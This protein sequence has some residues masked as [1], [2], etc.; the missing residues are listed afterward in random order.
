MLREESD[1]QASC[2]LR[3]GYTTGTCATA[4]SLAAA[5]LLLTRQPVTTMQVTLPRG[6]TTRLELTHCRLQDVY[7]E[8]GTLKDAGDD[9]DVTHQALVFAKVRL[10]DPA[11]I[12]FQAGQGVGTVTRPGLPVPLGE[13]AINPTPRRMM[14][15]HLKKLAQQQGYKG[16]FQVTIGVH[17]G[18]ELAKRTLNGRLGIVGGLSILGTT[19]IVR[20]FSCSAY[21]ASIHQTIDVAR[22]NG[23]CHLAACTGAASEQTIRAHY[24]L[25]ALAVVEMGDFVGAVLKYLK[26]APVAKLS[27]AG[28]FGKISKLAAGHLNLHSHHSQIDFAWLAQQ[29][30]SL[31][32]DHTL[33]A[34]IQTANTA[35][36]VL[37]LTQQTSLPLA[38]L[39]CQLARIKALNIL[40]DSIETEVWA[41]DRQGQRVGFA[42]P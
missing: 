32:A 17:N 20:P 5:Y 7:A 41:L 12:R 2:P 38:D 40:P 3:Y 10:I 21:I 23:L 34:A 27:L 24:G 16:G 6:Q 19:G 4:T 29:A 15:E 26:T 36:Q 1:E 30:V 37:T 33:T 25:P 18:E 39:I 28:G 8:A 22:A 42:G 14:T 11:E 31:G 9:P 35:Q 13:P